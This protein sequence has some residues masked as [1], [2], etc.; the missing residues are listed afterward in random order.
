[1]TSGSETRRVVR[2]RGGA[3]EVADELVVEAPME[4]RL[5]GEPIAVVMR[6]PGHD[7]DLALGFALT[8]GIVSS[9]ADL[10]GVEAVDSDRW[11]LRLSDGVQVDPTGFQR[12]FYATSSCGVCGKASIDA[13]RVAGVQPPPGPA[14]GIDVLADLPG[15]LRA[16]QQLFDATGGLHAAALFDAEGSLSVVREDVGRHNAVDKVVGAAAGGEWP[17]PPRGLMVSGRISFEIVQKAA[18]AGIGLICGVSAA[19]SLAVDLAEEFGMT[20]IGFLRE[21]G[22]TLYC[23][24]ERVAG[25]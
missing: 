4:I 7:E 6:T 20:V 18:V 2:V 14:V 12:N 13:I 8:E 3:G 9:P 25:L 16:E 1:M 23:G 10:A 19:S 5:G 22:F 11:E 17:I 24:P 15:R 21:P